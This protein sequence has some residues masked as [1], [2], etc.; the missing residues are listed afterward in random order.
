MFTEKEYINANKN[1]CIN[2]CICFYLWENKSFLKTVNNIMEY[3]KKHGYC[4]SAN[5]RN[6]IL[7]T[8]KLMTTENGVKKFISDFKKTYIS[9]SYRTVNDFIKGA[10]ET[11]GL[12]ALEIASIV[13]QQLSEFA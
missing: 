2:N 1:A 4:N 13:K 7:D 8:L 11:E 10:Y 5:M 6:A 12:T 9:P 3:T